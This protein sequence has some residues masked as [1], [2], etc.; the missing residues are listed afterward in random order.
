MLKVGKWF[1]FKGNNVS[2]S[3]RGLKIS[4]VL[5]I[6][7]GKQKCLKQRKRQENDAPVSEKSPSWDFWVVRGQRWR[8]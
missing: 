5:R 6:A 1:P 4:R 3:S 7:T 8:P 2:K